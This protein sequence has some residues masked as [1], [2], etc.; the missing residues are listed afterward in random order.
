MRSPISY[1]GGKNRLSDQIIGKIPQHVTFAEVFAG[2]AQVLCKK[3]PSKVEALNDLDGNV[4]N[5]FRCVQQ[6]HD[7]LCRYLR[8]VLVSR[9]WF[10]IFLNQNPASLTDIQRA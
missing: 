5:F 1:I 7:E 6:H 9:E 2:G 8:F 10:K 3:L 4:V